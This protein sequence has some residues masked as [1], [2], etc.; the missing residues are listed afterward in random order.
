ASASFELP[1]FGAPA[2][3]ESDRSP[4]LAGL[5]RRVAQYGSSGAD[6]NTLSGQCTTRRQ[7]VGSN[8]GLDLC[9]LCSIRVWRA[10]RPDVHLAARA[11]TY[12]SADLAGGGAWRPSG[13]RAGDL[14]DE[15]EGSPEAPIHADPRSALEENR[16]IRVH[17]R[18]SAAICL[19][20]L[21]LSLGAN[22]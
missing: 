1:V 6:P 19:L 10:E 8:E 22:F 17:R 14:D 21:P 4:A 9:S 15:R 2:H 20:V 3:E 5:L 7:P 12:A 18:S 11:R 13:D 16:I